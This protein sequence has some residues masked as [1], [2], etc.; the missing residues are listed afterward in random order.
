MKR[1]LIYQLVRL[2]SQY[3]VRV[4]YVN[5]LLSMTIN[6]RDQPKPSFN[7][8]RFTGKAAVISANSSAVSSF[9]LFV[10]K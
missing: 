9:D 2:R 4:P 6:F 3:N 7:V 10:V 1:T 8:V 5:L